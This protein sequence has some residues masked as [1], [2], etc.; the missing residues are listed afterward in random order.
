MENKIKIKINEKFR[1]I[2]TLS[3]MTFFIIFDVGKRFPHS[4]KKCKS[5]HSRHT[6]GIKSQ[7]A[8]EHLYCCEF[9][10][11]KSTAVRY[12]HNWSLKTHL[13]KHCNVRLWHDILKTVHLWLD[14][15]YAR[16]RYEQPHSNIVP[17]GDTCTFDFIK[18]LWTE[19]FR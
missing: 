17:L 10:C 13:E 9:M 1:T 4:Q 15:P 8:T 3:F 6:S 5:E 12:Y 14:P 16:T 7:H 19:R 11:I 2:K 18:H